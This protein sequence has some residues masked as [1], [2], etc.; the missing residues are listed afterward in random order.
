[1]MFALYRI[2][3]GLPVIVFGEAGVGKSA[4][5]RFLI[6][7]LLG[8]HFS[9]CN[10]NSG[11]SIQDISQM[12]EGA[13]TALANG[14][15]RA[16]VLL[17]EM[18]TSDPSVIAFL[19]ELML[20]RSFEGETLPE[21]LH[22]IGAANPYRMLKQS[23]ADASVGLAFRFAESKGSATMNRDLVYRVN[24]LPRAFYDHIYDFGYLSPDAENVYIEEIGHHSL[25]K[26][27]DS[28]EVS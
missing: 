22:L 4:L 15:E 10:V 17:D 6:Q 14:Q 26:D 5:F 21:N 3:C 23:D 2:R 8:H 25:A 19:K 24:E 9:V 1:M 13:R 27:Y 16:F 20:D 11:T 18:N 28:H 7:T 12:I